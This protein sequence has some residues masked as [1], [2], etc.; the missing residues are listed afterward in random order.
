MLIGAIDGF[1]YSGA[2][3]P[4]KTHESFPFV[5]EAPNLA[6][7]LTNRLRTIL[8]IGPLEIRPLVAITPHLIANQNPD[9]RIQ[10]IA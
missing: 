2:A 3:K 6:D 5:I 1:T 8:D 4:R 10:K 9:K 7:M